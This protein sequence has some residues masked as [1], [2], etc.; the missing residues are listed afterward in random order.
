MRSRVVGAVE[1]KGSEGRGMR[2]EGRQG[3]SKGKMLGCVGLGCVGLVCVALRCVALIIRRGVQGKE[4]KEGPAA[5]QSVLYFSLKFNQTGSETGTKTKTATKTGTSEKYTQETQYATPH[6]NTAPNNHN[7]KKDK[8]S[9]NGEITI[10]ALL[11][12]LFPLPLQ[13]QIP[14]TPINPQ[15]PPAPA[16]PPRKPPLPTPHQ[17]P[18]ND[19]TRN[20]RTRHHAV[21]EQWGSP[22][23]GGTTGK[24]RS[25]GSGE[26]DVFYLRGLPRGRAGTGVGWRGREKGNEDGEDGG[27]EGGGGKGKGKGKKE[28]KIFQLEKM[29]TGF[30]G[31]ENQNQNQNQKSTGKR[32]GKQASKQTSMS[33]NERVFDGN[34]F[35]IPRLILEYVSSRRDSLMSSHVSNTIFTSLTISPIKHTYKQISLFSLPEN[36][37][38]HQFT[39]HS[40][41]SKDYLPTCNS[42]FP[43]RR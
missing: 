36:N 5:G 42:T 24:D 18:P 13:A 11:P 22:G 7:L 17:E 20:P 31:K 41:T 28:K 15:N 29:N 33:S 26:L 16:N 43:R 38:L 10:L 39:C 12:R 4:Y 27:E 6:Y 34:G 19:R 30:Y 8:S 21:D 2:G 35:G 3:K 37:H 9:P 1:G 32:K 23:F 14:T 25:G 40:K